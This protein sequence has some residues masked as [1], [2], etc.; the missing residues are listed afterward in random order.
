MTMTAK[1]VSA[2]LAS[3]ADR[4]AAY[5]LPNGKK[6]SGEW[7]VG[8]LNGEAGE[9]LK[10]RVQGTKVGVW[11]DFA[12]S[13]GG[14]LLDLWAACHN[15]DIGTALREAKQW[16][17]IREVAMSTPAEKTYRKPSRP[18]GASK[19]L[20]Q[21][22]QW[23]AEVRKIGP[24]AV[25]AYQVA[26]VNHGS[27]GQCLVF[28]FK[29]GAELIAL[30]YRKVPGKEFTQ[31]AGC[32][33]ALFGWQA[34]PPTAR[35]VTIVEGEL[36][37]LACWQYG[38]PALS[39]PAGGGGGGKQ[40][41]IA[42]EF[43]NLARFDTIYLALDADG[44][45]QE[46]TA[47]IIKRL[48]QDRCLVVTLPEGC[49]DANDC[50]INGVDRV[51][52]ADCFRAARSVDP[53]ELRDISEFTDEVERIIS[54]S[55]SGIPLP[56][57]KCGQTLLMRPGETIVLAG[58]NGHGKALC[59]ETPIATPNGWARFGDI[60]P[61]SV[62]FDE[63]GKP[64]NVI[65]E[66]PVQLERPCYR[67]EF[68]DG[69]SIV[70]D[71]NH[72][73]LTSSAV[74]RSS[75]RNA[76][77]PK[78]G[79]GRAQTEKQTGPRVVTTLEIANS[80]HG[81][82]CRA[83]L[84][85]HSI[86]VAG[87]LEMPDA[88]LPLEPYLLG[89]WLGDG[90]S[91]DNGITIA[92][93]QL[94]LEL[95]GLGHELVKSAAKYRYGIRGGFMVTA[96]AVGVLNN[97]HIPAAYLRSSARQRMAL[98]QGL[99]DT[100][101]CATTYGRCEFTNKNKALAEGVLELAMTLGIQ[102]TMIEGRATLYGKD[103]GAKYRVCF[104]TSAPVFRLERKLN[105]LRAD[106]S[107]RNKARFIIA[108][109]PVESV[110][111]KCIQVDSSSSLFLAGRSMIPTHNSQMVGWL[112][113]NAI[114]WHDVTA[115]VASLEFKTA[116]WLARMVKQATARP[117]PSSGQIR[118]VMHKLSGAMYSF[119]LQSGV[120]YKRMLEVFRYARN[121]YDCRLFV[122]DNLAK[123]GIPEDDYRAQHEF[124]QV[125]TN[126]NRDNDTTTILVHHMRKGDSEDANP[127]K[128]SVKGSGSITDLADTV[129]AIWRNKKKE[130]K[131]KTAIAGGIP[132]A[133]D[134]RREEDAV[135]TCSKQRNGD[136]EP[137]VRLWF[138]RQSFQYLAQHDHEPKPVYGLA[139]VKEYSDER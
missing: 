28:P 99:M 86:A 3:V 26:Q 11:A 102:A 6:S 133:D 94:V 48:G 2:S 25:A 56:W 62:V 34:I 124:M 32:E 31:E 1:E 7:C 36:D 53:V 38:Y 114:R 81:T 134:V 83:H 136:D 138:D 22:M 126:F 42:H 137:I 51:E 72:E 70:A 43:D 37:A 98:L 79:T 90:T 63:N 58:I 75:A 78:I 10:V 113:L 44:P 85:N 55:D 115:C 117:D 45:G 120:N 71:A 27:L 105:R 128:M 139:S 89:C 39:V 9:S 40:Q 69:S 17:G 111:V 125:L 68:S 129:L 91:S 77:K 14:D 15:C 80:L 108:C 106:I 67:V 97:K 24:E 104:T 118:H 122:I 46:A 12:T 87:A 64:C 16:L 100:D 23:L 132:V 121:R 35:S 119:D 47:E 112:L 59:I 29:R 92:D 107:D 33:P 109:D 18:A 30:K 50:A 19:P 110:P 116:K 95:R 130:M 93:E 66:T 127:G 8:S 135:L 54:G 57:K 65:A 52:F 76:K 4:V 61:G 88:A 73:W 84:M 5:L 41:W 103:C 13:E 60:R 96:R 101:G 131:V 82:G 123:C 74:A 21:T 20:P 49:K